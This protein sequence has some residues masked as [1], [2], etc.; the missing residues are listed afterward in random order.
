MSKKTSIKTTLY[1]SESD[2]R[3][4]KS[5]AR[6]QGIAAAQCVREAVA[7]YIVNRS[8]GT[9]PSSIGAGR[10]GRAD[11]SERA[12]ELLAGMGEA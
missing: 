4:L 10:S 2:Y 6:A 9:R 11:L 12:E 1:L 8:A 3:H 5:I 7:E